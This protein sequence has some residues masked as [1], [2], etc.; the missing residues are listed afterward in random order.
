[1]PTGFGIAPDQNGNGTTPEDLQ[2]IWGAMYLSDGVIHGCEVSG[3]SDMTYSVSAGA[4]V[5]TTGKD[6]K[7]LV[8]VQATTIP[9]PQAPATGTAQHRIYVRQQMPG[10]DGSSNVVVAATAGNVPAGALTLDAGPIAANATSTAAFRSNHDRLFARQVGASL[11]RLVT[12]SDS[13][14]ARHQG[15]AYR[16]GSGRFFVPTDRNI[17]LRLSSTPVR[18]SA[19][20][21]ALNGSLRAALR[22]EIYI[23][24]NH[25]KSYVQEYSGV[26]AQTQQF[27]TEE[28]VSY[29][30]HT[31]HV[32][33]Q[34][35]YLQD[36]IYEPNDYWQ[37][38][39]G[40][41][42]K[43]HGTHLTISDIGV[44]E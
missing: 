20:G 13:S 10:V 3:R 31:F 17:H 28:A 8:P 12:V 22:H 24:G 18:T 25:L 23:D 16:W 5:M 2:R 39:E 38:R 11:G 21:L 44:R 7:V 32:I 29:G 6:M 9:A 1:M 14:A 35:V 30:D 36:G 41:P 15:E 37:V 33:T 34:R 27:I 43:Y 4:V 26:F 42:L 40:G 19:T